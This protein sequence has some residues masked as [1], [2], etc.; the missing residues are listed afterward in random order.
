[1][2]SYNQTT[3]SRH[4]YAPEAVNQ[5]NQLEVWHQS[6]DKFFDTTKRKIKFKVGDYVRILINKG[7]FEKG[8]TQTFSNSIDEVSE[9]LNTT[10]VMYKLSDS[11][12]EVLGSFYN[13]ELSKVNKNY[14]FS[15]NTEGSL[16]SPTFK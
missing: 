1:M 7:V 2:S 3:H 5:S 14:F 10:P 9:I 8:S 13:E 12:G 4:G 15:F 11:K 16:H 6:F